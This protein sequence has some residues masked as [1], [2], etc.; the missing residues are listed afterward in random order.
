MSRLGLCPCAHLFL[1][2]EGYD[3]FLSTGILQK[4]QLPES[5]SSQIKI[6]HRIYTFFLT[7]MSS[8]KPQQL[9]ELFAEVKRAQARGC[10]NSHCRGVWF[11]TATSNCGSAAP[12]APIQVLAETNSGPCP[13]NGSRGPTGLVKH[14]VTFPIPRVSLSECQPTLQRASHLTPCPPLYQET[15]RISLALPLS[16]SCHMGQVAIGARTGLVI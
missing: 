13:D 2:L 1:C 8:R 15:G 6:G 11:G 14:I 10:H 7:Q 3:F 5:K 12:A 9:P 16:L 4:A